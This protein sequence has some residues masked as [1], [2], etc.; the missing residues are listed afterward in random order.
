MNEQME[1]P[2]TWEEYEQEYG[3][4]DSDE[5]Y[6]NNSRLIQS[7]RVKQWLDHLEQEPC[8]D[9]VSRGVFDQVRWER[10]IAISQLKVLGYE[11]GQKV[12]PC[13]NTISRQAVLDLA[14]KGVLVSN[15]NFESVCKA[16]NEL[17]S[18]NMPCE[19]SISR[20]DLEE[21][22]ELMTDINGDTVFAVRM[23]DIR[24]LPSVNLTKTGHWIDIMVGDMPAQACDRCN[25]FYPLA[26]TGGG[27]KYCPNCGAK[28]ESEE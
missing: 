9:M 2:E 18:V 27:H 22:K 21:C 19:D 17:P 5:V 10:D 7:F 1:F 23:S 26:Y 28:M 4:N 6:T 24:Q 15:G 14:K 8:D 25:T 20:E 16:I 13:E 3:F 11:L 12:E